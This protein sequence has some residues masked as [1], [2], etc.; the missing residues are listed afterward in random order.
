M[1]L[2]LHY[3][4]I[5]ERDNP[6]E[7]KRTRYYMRRFWHLYK[8]YPDGTERNV[9]EWHLE[10]IIR[11]SPKDN[12]FAWRFHIGNSGS[13]TPWDGHLTLLGFSI[14]WGLGFGRKLA[15]RLTRCDG[16]QYDSRDWSLRIDDRRV[17]W[18]FAQHSDMCR[19]GDRVTKRNYKKKRK[20]HNTW[21]RGNFVISIPELI[22]GPY[23]YTYE[24]LEGANL[25]I[26]L[27]E[28]AYAV[29][30]MLRKVYFG[31]TKV[32]RDKHEVSYSFDVDAPKGIPTHVDH[33]GGWKG[34]RTYGFGV[35]YPGDPRV[36]WRRDAEAAIA[37]WVLEYRARTGF[38]KAD[39]VE[40]AA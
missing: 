14:Y 39:P 18:E 26:K 30:V 9:A 38:R 32:S 34:D 6:R 17:W 36:D 10:T 31:R 19:R 3:H 21:R 28:D 7:R 35:N 22:W 12:L 4:K 33:S 16:Y 20:R 27:P 40:G 2:R 25:L 23:R 8:V 15:D 13:E 11:K 37:A 5:N 24:D 29:T 1:K